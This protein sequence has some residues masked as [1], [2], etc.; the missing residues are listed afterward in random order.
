[1]GGEI[2][3]AFSHVFAFA[4]T[5]FMIFRMYDAYRYVAMLGAAIC[6]MISFLVLYLL[7]RKFGIY[8]GAWM[9]LCMAAGIISLL[10]MRRI[11]IAA[12][13]S[14]PILAFVVDFGFSLNSSF[15]SIIYGISFFI[16][17]A[18]SALAAIFFRRSVHRKKAM[19]ILKSSKQNARLL[20]VCANCRF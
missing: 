14:A 5:I 9:G 2:L 12:L 19:S 11:T 20:C 7:D 6:A 13:F 4:L 3:I 1:M 17:P 15:L 8:V 10:Y 18:L 16:F